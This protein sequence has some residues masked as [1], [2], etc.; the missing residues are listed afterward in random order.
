VFAPPLHARRKLIAKLGVGQVVRLCVRFDARRWRRLLPVTLRRNAR[1][2]FGFIHSR[3]E[4][5]PVWWALSSAPDMT[6]WGGGPAAARLARRS[7]C[8]VFEKALSSLARVLAVAKADLRRAVVAWETHNWARDPFSR[9]AYSFIV[10]GHEDAAEKIRE[11]MQK[12][13]FFAGEATADGEEVGTVHGALAS[14]LRAAE[15]A[16]AALRKT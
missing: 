12:T 16:V 13:L 10:A 1:G 6:G 15:E 7:K 14:G 3:V 5:V 11:P 2:G 4:G 8:G 9:G